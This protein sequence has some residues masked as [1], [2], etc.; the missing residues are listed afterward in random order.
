[1]SNSHGNQ[2]I[3]RTSDDFL[4]CTGCGTQYDVTAE[5]GKDSCA[6][7]DDPRQFVPPEGQSFTT[8]KQMREEGY[9]NEWWQEPTGDERV[10]FSRTVPRVSSTTLHTMTEG[11]GGERR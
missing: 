10:W 11:V 1:M 9:A 2:G 5:S 8:L 7:C 4:I 6:I 3:L